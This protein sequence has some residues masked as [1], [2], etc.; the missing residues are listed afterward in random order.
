MA[1]TNWH[2]VALKALEVTSP[3][4][5]PSNS[6]VLNPVSSFLNKTADVVIGGYI[7]FVGV[8][9]GNYRKAIFG[10]SRADIEHR[11]RFEAIINRSNS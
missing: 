8:D 4:G 11:K 1:Q 7:Q 10:E 5:N 3:D 2:A 6:D 9:L